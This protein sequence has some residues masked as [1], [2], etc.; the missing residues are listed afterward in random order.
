MKHYHFFNSLI[1]LNTDENNFHHLISGIGQVWTVGVCMACPAN[2][3]LAAFQG[4]QQ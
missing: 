2:T 1:L 3:V 4:I